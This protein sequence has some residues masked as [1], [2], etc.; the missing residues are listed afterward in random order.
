MES[1]EF[2][3]EE[4]KARDAFL[5]ALGAEAAAAAKKAPTVV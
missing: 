2:N 4:L 5:A 3:E 1:D